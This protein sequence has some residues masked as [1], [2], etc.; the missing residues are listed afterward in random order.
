MQRVT[1]SPVTLGLLALTVLFVPPLRTQVDW[2]VTTRYDT[3]AAYAAYAAAWPDG[4]HRAEAL[5][6]EDALAWQ[7][8]ASEGTIAAYDAYLRTHASG[9]YASTARTRI[10]DL[11]W[12]DALRERSAASLEQ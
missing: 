10:D 7:A 12:A 1:A 6:R 11:S 4:P 5:A 9:T 8:A 2:L 3:H